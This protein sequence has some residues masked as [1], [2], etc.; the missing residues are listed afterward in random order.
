MPDIDGCTLMTMMREA[1]P[2]KRAPIVALT[3]NLLNHEPERLL[4]L[5]FDYFLSKPIDE[6]KFRLLLDGSPR[7]PDRAA[8]EPVK[9]DKYGKMLSVDFQNSLGLCAFKKS[10]LDKMLETLLK[11]IPGHQQQ[12]SSQLKQPDY[13]ILSDTIHK[14]HGIT[15]YTSLPRLRKQVLSIQQQLN[16]KSYTQVDIA[17]ES[18]ILEFEEIRQQ[19]ERYLGASLPVSP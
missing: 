3:A 18:V 14:I 15:C 1:S 12:L 4:E 5:G 19:V 8:D 16:Q 2:D 11:E 10:L 17:I 9:A 6:D 7:Q 13:A